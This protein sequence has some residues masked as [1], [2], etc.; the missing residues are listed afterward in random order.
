MTLAIFSHGQDNQQTYSGIA[1]N[2]FEINKGSD[3]SQSVA[4]PSWIKNNAG[5]WSKGEIGDSDFVQGI[6]YLIQNK[7]MKIPATQAGSGTGQT[8]PSWIKTN[9]G[10]WAE[11]KITDNDFVQGIQWLIV[12]GIMKV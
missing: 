12:N 1:S 6:Q 10:W 4:I 5:W 2:T 9:A 7:I 11:G 8:I 3:G